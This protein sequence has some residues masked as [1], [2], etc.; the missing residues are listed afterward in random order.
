MTDD[1][2]LPT[3]P[4]PTDWEAVEDEREE[5]LTY[6]A[7]IARTCDPDTAK[8]EI[9]KASARLI[10]LVEAEYAAIRRHDEENGVYA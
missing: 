5:V 1:P 7:Y 4:L 8:V 10:A 6:L 9:E 2:T 3:G